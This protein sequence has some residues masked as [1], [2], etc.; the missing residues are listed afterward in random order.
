MSA[1][2]TPSFRTLYPE[3]IPYLTDVLIRPSAS[4]HIEHRVYYECCGNPEGIPVLFLHGGPGSGCRP[5]HRCFFDPD[6]YHI[7][8]MDQRGCGRSRPLGEL[9]SNTTQDLVDDLELLREKLDISHWVIFAG[10]WGSTLGLVYA[11]HYPQ[12][13]VALILRGTFLGRS[14][15]IDWVY[16]R[17]GAAR[18]FPEAWQQLMALVPDDAS[19]PLS[20][21]LE[22]LCSDNPEERTR[23][24]LALFHWQYVVGHF[25]HTPPPKSLD[26]E[27]LVAHYRI[28]MHY[29]LHGCF[30]DDTPIL[31]RLEAIRTLP[32]WLVQGRYDLVCPSHQTLALHQALPDSHLHIVHAAGHSATEAAVIDVLVTITDQLADELQ[33]MTKEMP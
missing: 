1:A 24:A 30:I 4:G 26:F 22:N 20:Y 29:A 18:L 12:H 5:Y 23:T 3:L 25:E 17:D 31:S 8:L 14:E 11:Q 9:E 33:P 2:K 19:S 27:Q 21:F 7:I 28:Q 15:D 16:Q 10:S 13:V 6:R 32:T